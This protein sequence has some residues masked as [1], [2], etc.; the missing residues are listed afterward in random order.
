MEVFLR[1]RTILNDFFPLI[2]LEALMGEIR[3]E[4][5]LVRGAGGLVCKGVELLLIYVDWEV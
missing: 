3:K 1:V 2:Q 4:L 5:R